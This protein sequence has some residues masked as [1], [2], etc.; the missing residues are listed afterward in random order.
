MSEEIVDQAFATVTDAIETEY[1]S[2][3]AVA[4]NG[5]KSAKEKALSQLKA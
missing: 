3:K 1:S 5:V 2:A 4:E